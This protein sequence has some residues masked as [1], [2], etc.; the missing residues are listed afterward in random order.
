MYD[1]TFIRQV[2]TAIH[3]DRVAALARNRQVRRKAPGALVH[4][5]LALYQRLMSPRVAPHRAMARDACAC[6]NVTCST[7][8]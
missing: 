7:C 2:T 4:H 6:N 8:N 3:E 1:P 5:G